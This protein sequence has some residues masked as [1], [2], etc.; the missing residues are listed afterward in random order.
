VLLL[1]MRLVQVCFHSNVGATFFL[2]SYLCLNCAMYT[3]K[4]YERDQTAID[5]DALYGQRLAIMHEIAT[6][7]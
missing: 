4:R 6:V 1:A 5:I 2:K 7:L 3:S